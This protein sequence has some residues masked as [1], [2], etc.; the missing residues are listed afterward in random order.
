MTIA[1]QPY[2]ERAS[3][4]R[5]A[6]RHHAR[7]DPGD[8]RRARRSGLSHPR[9]AAEF[10]ASVR[11]HCAAEPPAT[12]RAASP[13]PGTV[14]DPADVA[15]VRDA[16]GRLIVMPH[17]DLAVVREAKRAGMLALPGVAT[18]TEAFAALD[19][20][21]DGLK[22]FPAEGL[23]PA[24]AEGVARGAAA[25]PRSC[26]RSAASGPTTMAPY[27]AAG[28]SGFG[29]GSNLYRPGASADDVRTVAASFAAAFRR[30]ARAMS[31]AGVADGR[32]ARRADD[33][34]QP[35]ARRRSVRLAARLRRRY[36]EHGDRRGATC[37]AAAPI[38]AGYVTRVGNDAFGRMFLSLWAREGVARRRRE[39]SMREAPTGVYFVSHG[40]QGHEF[41]Y[42][43]AGSAASRMSPATLPLDVLR[44]ARV[45]HVSGISQAISTSACDACFAAIDVVREAGGQVS[46]DPNLRLK[47]WP[48]ARARAI[49][50]ASVALADWVLPSYDDARL[51]FDAEAP[52]AIVDAL[53]ALGRAG[54]RAEARR[55][56]AASSPT[57]GGASASP[58]IAS[59]RSMRRAPAIAST[60]RSPCGRWPATIRF[61]RRAMRTSPRLSR[62]PASAPSRRCPTMRPCALSRRGAVA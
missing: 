51:L 52:D 15:R 35:V 60:A 55:A 50:R 56:R 28:A 38:R 23:P 22:M 48:L 26:S 6:A 59:I 9:G 4:D 30:A 46:Y 12:A 53:H 13:A 19:A 57:A 39:R 24:G 10:A 47:L 11:Q 58:D 49:V 41:S 1:L 14:R 27:W 16:G 20:G 62:R 2:S 18:P 45:L 36:V 5:R 43:R 7:G 44:Q 21:A 54:R 17:A 25:S 40:P 32:R 34:V 33:R 29:T 3:A 31:A 37:R 42:L 8:R 61:A